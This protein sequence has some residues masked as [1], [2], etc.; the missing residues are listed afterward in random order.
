MRSA[1]SL[2]KRAAVEAELTDLAW[3]GVAD[4]IRQVTGHKLARYARATG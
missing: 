4:P 3:A 1:C 2:R